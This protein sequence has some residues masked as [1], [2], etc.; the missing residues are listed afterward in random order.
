[1]CFFDLPKFTDFLKKWIVSGVLQKQILKK[2]QEWFSVGLKKWNISR[3]APYFGFKI[4]GF[5]DKYFYVWMDAPIGY[6]ST[7]KNLCSKR[8]DL[9]F[10]EYWN[11]NSETELYHFIGKD[12]IYFHT[13]FWPSILKA[14]SFRVPTQICVHGYVTMNGYKISK[15]KGSIISAKQWLKYFDS[16]SLRYYYS[17]K[18]SSN[19]QDIEINLVEFLQKI[20]ADLVNKIVNLASRCSK[21]INNNCDSI[22]STDLLDIHIYN[23][24][25]K[26]SKIIEF[27]FE[28]K[29]Y[30]AVIR[31]ILELADFANAYINKTAP[32]SLPSNNI[33]CKTRVQMIYTMG[34]NFFRVLLTW[35]KPIVPKLACRSE[36]FLNL[37]LT[38][39][40]ISVPILNHRIALFRPL[41]K[42]LNMM[43]VRLLIKSITIV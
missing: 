13:L 14:C 24:F 33:Q 32:W 23:D 27:L 11:E 37:E 26:N 25:I 10:N 19:V 20:N 15:S 9:N 3:D 7:F 42:R 12:I 2:S 17:S 5:C 4:P 39:E 16:D 35:L 30:S 40:G 31:K 18:L 6:I 1:M 21:F 22:L 41:Y 43:Q 38:W 29:K 36:K 28:H 34:I 8:N